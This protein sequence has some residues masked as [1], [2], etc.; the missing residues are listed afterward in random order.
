MVVGTGV[1]CSV[2]YGF[3]APTKRVAATVTLQESAC[4]GHAVPTMPPTTPTKSTVQIQDATSILTGQLRSLFETSQQSIYIYADDHSKSCNG[5][6]ASLL[7]YASPTE[8]AENHG[9]FPEV[10]VDTGSR[11]TLIQAYQNAIQNGVGSTNRITWRTKTGK[12]VPTTCI[13]VPIDQGGQRVA[14]HFI[15]PT[16]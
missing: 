1:A 8:W 4:V 15:T 16:T 14:L 7:G 10:F 9:N 13:L 6:F 5:R 11:N 2:A 12:T 3:Q